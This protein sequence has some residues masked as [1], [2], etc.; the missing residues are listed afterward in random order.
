M[1]LEGAL[2]KFLYEVRKWSF[3]SY[4]NFELLLESQLSIESVQTVLAVRFR[5]TIMDGKLIEGR[6]SVYRLTPFWTWRPYL[7]L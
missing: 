3:W 6:S 5:S 2:E 4:F 7:D 1:A